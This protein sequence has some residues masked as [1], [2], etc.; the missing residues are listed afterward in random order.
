MLITTDLLFAEW[1]SVLNSAKM[2][3]VLLDRLQPPLQHHQSR[4]RRLAVQKSQSASETH[5][6]I[7]PQEM[8]SVSHVEGGQCSAPFESLIKRYRTSLAHRCAS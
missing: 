4:K 7:D 6:P 8:G 5:N 3:S 1:L 2:T